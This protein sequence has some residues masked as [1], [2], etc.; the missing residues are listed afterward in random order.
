MSDL[1]LTEATE[2]AYRTY[3]EALHGG[4]MRDGDF[5]ATRSSTEFEWLRLVVSDVA[6]LIEAQVREQIAAEIEASM[7]AIGH[8][9]ANATE[10][11]I[12]D[13]VNH[14]LA[15]YAH[16]AGIARGTP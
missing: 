12:P 9:Q 1:D 7:N 10:G 2:V 8:A 13:V 14:I 3:C 15:G 4:A 5:E 11:H 16:A 6:P